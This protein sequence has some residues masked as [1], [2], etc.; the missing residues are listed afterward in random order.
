MTDQ[1][2]GIDEALEGV[3]RVAVTAAARV[4]ERLA[5]LREEFARDARARSEQQARELQVRYDAERAAARAELR[6]VHE[7][8]WWDRA[9][10]ASVA[11]AYEV[12]TAWRGQ[13]P[14]AASA[15]DRIADEVR[16]RYGFDVNETGELSRQVLLATEEAALARSQEAAERARATDEAAEAQLLIAEANALDEFAKENRA[17]A[18]ELARG[19]DWES[20]D[21]VDAELFELAEENNATADE[22]QSR[23]TETAANAADLY[24]TSERR[25]QFANDLAAKGA[26]AEQVRDRLLSDVDQAKHPR[27]AVGARKAGAKA[28][29]TR[30]TTG[31]A[32]DRA[33]G[34]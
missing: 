16:E 26:N 4:G 22:Q 5:R 23:S 6:P 32:R 27:E 2:D 25:E 11:R 31:A 20:P 14:N 12:A 28:R 21:R 15:A 7:S 29:P 17:R 30:G 34:R 24:D 1:G 3:M 9:D 33:R 8:T 19:I 18:D 13:D 10:A